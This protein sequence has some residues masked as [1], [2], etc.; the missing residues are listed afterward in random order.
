MGDVTSALGSM[1]GGPRR[2]HL[3]QERTSLC[4]GRHLEDDAERFAGG[5]YVGGAI[6][7]LE[8][9]LTR[10]TRCLRLVADGPAHC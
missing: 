6:E 2:P 5:Q 8:L 10:A 3:A 1:L 4:R 7:I 9:H